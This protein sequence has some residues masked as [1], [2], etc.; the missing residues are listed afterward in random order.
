MHVV[1]IEMEVPLLVLGPA[2]VP[3][4]IFVLLFS[5]SC[6]NNAHGAYYHLRPLFFC[7][8]VFPNNPTSK[9]LPG[10]ERGADRIDVNALFNYYRNPAEH[11][12]DSFR[13]AHLFFYV[14]QT[15]DLAFRRGLIRT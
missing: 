11:E 15:R 14:S 5:D 7:L 10:V 4:L 8:S 1:R 2:Y 12:T 13:G 9:C 6:L 3:D